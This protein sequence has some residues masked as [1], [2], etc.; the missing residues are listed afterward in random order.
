M[1]MAT[2]DLLEILYVDWVPLFSDEKRVLGAGWGGGRDFISRRR[3]AFK[4]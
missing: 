2:R 4:S 3:G 1:A